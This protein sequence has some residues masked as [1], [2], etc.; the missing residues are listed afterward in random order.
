[1]F[2]A[3]MKMADLSDTTYY[4]KNEVFQQYHGLEPRIAATFMLD[5]YSSMKA[6]YSRGISIPSFTI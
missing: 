5:E 4:G 3:T 2:I 1:M 6:S